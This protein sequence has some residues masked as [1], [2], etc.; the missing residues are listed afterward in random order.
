VARER[1]SLRG[2]GLSLWGT[3]LA[4][5]SLEGLMTA[6]QL[7][8]MRG[9]DGRAPGWGEALTRSLCSAALWV[10]LTAGLVALVRRRPLGRAGLGRTAAT[11]AAAAV[12][13]FVARALFVAG[14][15]PWVGWYAS[16]PPF[17]ELLTTSALVNAATVTALLGLGHAHYFAARARRRERQA[18]RLRARLTGARLRALEAQ[19]RPHFLFNTLNALSELVHG[20]PNAADRMLVN[21]GELLR[22]SLAAGAS[23]EVPLAEE[24]ATLRPYVEIQQIRYGARFEFACEVEPP[25]LGALVPPFVLQPLVENAVRHGVGARAGRGR[26]LVAAGRSGGA[27]VVRVE[28]ECGAGAAPGRGRGIGLANVRGRLRGLYGRAQSLTLSAP[29]AGT[30]VA[31][32]TVPWREPGGGA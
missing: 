28:N 3:S 14:L 10:P 9:P 8:L 12:A 20:D 17:F 26:V 4:G 15:N 22:R 6:A 16:V 19:L 18:A 11:Y 5:W 21:L 29:R 2:P 31:T 13:V 23:R 27:L 32:L 25:A 24:L 1:L 30:A 7:R